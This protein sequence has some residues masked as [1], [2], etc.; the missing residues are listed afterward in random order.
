MKNR[1]QPWLIGPTEPLTGRALRHGLVLHPSLD[2]V[3]WS[4][5]KDCWWVISDADTGCSV[6][7][8]V[9]PDPIAA[10][11]SW[12]QRANGLVSDLGLSIAEILDR[13]R[14]YFWLGEDLLQQ[15]LTA[16]CPIDLPPLFLEEPYVAD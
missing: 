15:A 1:A 4:F 14:R 16:S 3:P 8:G 9:Y 5:K 11:R 12:R 2:A 7:F 10:L 6:T 13:H